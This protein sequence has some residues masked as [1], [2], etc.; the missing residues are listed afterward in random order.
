[1]ASSSATTRLWTMWSRVTRIISTR[2]SASGTSSIWS[3]SCVRSGMAAAIPTLR[4][5]SI[6]SWLDRSTR[7]AT[8]RQPAE[9]LA[10]PVRLRRRHARRGK[11]AHIEAEGLLGGY[12]ARR[13]VR[14]GKVAF[15]GQI[16]H[17]VADRGRAESLCRHLEMV[18]DPTGSPVSI[19]VRTIVYRISRYRELS[20]ASVLIWRKPQTP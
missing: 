14:L 15:I 3:S 17:D 9:F 1:M 11:R 19:Y 5:N 7:S 20:G 2:R 6:S 4:V 10:Q 18:R 8:C 13:G 16:G 12:P